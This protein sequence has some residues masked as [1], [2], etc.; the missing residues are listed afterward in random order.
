MNKITGLANE[1]LDTIQFA[2]NKALEPFQK[3]NLKGYVKSIDSKTGKFIVTIDGKDYKL[4]NG[5]G[6]Q[7]VANDI[8]WVHA[9]MSDMNKAYICAKANGNAISI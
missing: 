6:I 5:V 2:I 8:V 9:P 7:I 1:I 4:Y 3:Q